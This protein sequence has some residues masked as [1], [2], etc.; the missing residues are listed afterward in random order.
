MIDRALVGHATARTTLRIDAWHV[1]LFCQATGEGDA[2]YWDEAVAH[3]A[4]HP[5]CPV[6]TTFLKAL[7]NEHF[8]AS[9]LLALMGAPLRGVLHAGQSFEFLAPLHVGDTVAISRR[10]ADIYD[11]KNGALTF[12]VVDTDYRSGERTV[13]T[14]RQTILL[15]AEVEPA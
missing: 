11:K 7:E 3:V 12:I 15:R 9:A 13:A 4:G 5:A 1:K 6:P 2:V 10:I 14:S 8:G